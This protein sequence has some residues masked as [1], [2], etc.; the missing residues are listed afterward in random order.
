MIDAA[1]IVKAAIPDA[2]EDTI[3][4]VLWART[5]YPF[6]GPDDFARKL[7]RAASRWARAA[8]NGVRLCEM[9][10]RIAEQN[11]WTCAV[12]R[13]GLDRVASESLKTTRQLMIWR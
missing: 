10:D 12:C 6:S 9:C 2:D 1:R 3:G 7:Y 11:R 5:A 4:H 8:T 13:E